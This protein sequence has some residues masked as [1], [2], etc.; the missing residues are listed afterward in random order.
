[1]KYKVYALYIVYSICIYSTCIEFTNLL[2]IENELKY[3]K[4]RAGETN[5]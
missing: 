3:E 2:S 4:E 1:M 5:E